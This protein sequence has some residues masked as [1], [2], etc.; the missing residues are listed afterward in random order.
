MITFR[1]SLG[2][3]MV[4]MLWQFVNLIGV[5]AE[6]SLHQKRELFLPQLFLFVE[7]YEMGVANH[8][9]GFY[10]FTTI[11]PKVQEKACFEYFGAPAVKYFREL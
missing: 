7:V 4:F 9:V 5:I 8:G 3:L 11:D 2:N 10:R 1:V 6:I